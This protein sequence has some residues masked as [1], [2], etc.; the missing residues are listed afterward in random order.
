MSTKKVFVTVAG[1]IGSGKSSLTRMIGDHFNWRPYFESVSDNPYL[2]DFYKDMERW[3]FHLQVYFLSHRFRTHVRIVNSKRSVI[4]DRSIYEDAEIFARN[5][6]DMGNMSKRDYKNYTALFKEMTAFLK[7]PD[8]LVYLRANTDTLVK[9]I[10]LR[11]RTFEK[12]IERSYLQL[13]N[14]S[15]ESWISK[16]DHSNCIIIESDHLDFVKNP[17]DL[18]FIINAVKKEL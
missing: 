13:L 18:D 15:Y 7:P 5:L 16:Y 10:T 4:Q 14:D 17:N 2:K 9:Q 3:S 11:G 12:S 1:N 6:Y 8:L